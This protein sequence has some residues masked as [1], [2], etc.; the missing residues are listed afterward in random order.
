MTKS[1]LIALAAITFL[2]VKASNVGQVQAWNGRFYGCV[3]NNSTGGWSGNYYCSDGNCYNGTASLLSCS[4]N[5]TN[6]FSNLAYA[7]TYKQT[8]NITSDPIVNVVL[9]ASNGGNWL[10][11]NQGETIRL[12]VR[13]MTDKSAYINLNY[14]GGT[15]VNNTAN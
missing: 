1:T 2:S 14:N 12:S 11:L 8:V 3:V 4:N 13:S 15:P 6:D 7:P 10:M 9:N 5:F